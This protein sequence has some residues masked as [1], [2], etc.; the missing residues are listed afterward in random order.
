VVNRAFLQRV[1]FGE[2][3]KAQR[4]REVESEIRSRQIQPHPT[5]RAPQPPPKQTKPVRFT[6]S[7]ESV[8]RAVFKGNPGWGK[9]TL[10]PRTLSLDVL[11]GLAPIRRRSSGGNK[12]DRSPSRSQATEGVVVFR[13]Y[14]PG[15]RGAVEVHREQLAGQDYLLA[16]QEAKEI[17]TCPELHH[18]YEGKSTPRWRPT[19]APPP[20][21][22][23]LRVS[24]PATQ[25]D[26]ETP[27]AY[28]GMSATILEHCPELLDFRLSMGKKGS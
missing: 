18:K 8:F 25:P 9:S 2:V 7:A 5:A 17:W 24:A 16:L 26:T 20:L 23:W 13:N 12:G 1:G 11:F 28:S 27:E 6:G 4:Q 22:M 14:I 3:V 19:P 15:Q 21:P 10:N